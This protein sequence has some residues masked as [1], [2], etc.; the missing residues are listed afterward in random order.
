VA[1]AIWLAHGQP[2]AARRL[3]G[4]SLT[5]HA[6]RQQAVGAFFGRVLP[7]TA[8]NTNRQPA[9][10]GHNQK[11]KEKNIMANKVIFTEYKR[12]ECVGGVV[13]FFAGSI[14]GEEFSGDYNQEDGL[15]IVP[16]TLHGVVAKAISKGLS[17]YPE[18]ICQPVVV[19]V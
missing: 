14:D 2:Y 13:A 16:E 19:E 8:G 9:S 15:S 1:V 18:G 12:E 7:P 10:C 11:K 5:E 17:S 4:L 3:R 6:T